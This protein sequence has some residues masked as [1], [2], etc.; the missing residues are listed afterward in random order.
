MT[1]CNQSDNISPQV[2]RGH[3][4]LVFSEINRLGPRPVP[5]NNHDGVV[6]RPLSLG[7]ELLSAA[8]EDDGARLALGDATEEVKPLTSDLKAKYHLIHN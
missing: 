6:Q 3:F 8:A 7:H 5:A 2:N 4:P 1:R